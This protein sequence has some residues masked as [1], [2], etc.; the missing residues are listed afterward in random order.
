MTAGWREEKE[1]ARNSL[2]SRTPRAKL[3]LTCF[4]QKKKNKEINKK[5][6]LNAKTASFSVVDRS[7]NPVK[8]CGK[9]NDPR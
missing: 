3:H 8:K 4:L 5:V 2:R 6:H 1:K 7:E 9:A